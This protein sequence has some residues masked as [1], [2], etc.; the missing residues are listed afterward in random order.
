MRTQSCAAVK[1]RLNDREIAA[2]KRRRV[3]S[4]ERTARKARRQRKPTLATKESPLPVE[5]TLQLD[6]REV[7]GRGN[8]RGRRAD[9][10][11]PEWD[12]GSACVPI[13]AR[14][15]P[16]GWT[17]R[18]AARSNSLA[19][20]TLSG[21]D[22]DRGG[23]RR[24]EPCGTTVVTATTT[25]SSVS[26][27][28][29]GGNGR[30]PNLAGR[31]A[32]RRG[33]IAQLF[34]RAAECFFDERSVAGR[35]AVCSIARGAASANTAASCGWRASLLSAAAPSCSTASEKPSRTLRRTPSRIQPNTPVLL[36]ASPCKEVCRPAGPAAGKMPGGE[37][38]TKGARWYREAPVRKRAVRP[39]TKRR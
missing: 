4:A 27:R 37:P 2:V 18:E 10:C 8:T 23:R 9:R 22:S 14:G 31:V 3:A 36:I 35:S 28:L 34:E 25:M 33:R 29:S 15:V 20:N 11:F 1:C 21:A 13:N 30:E 32:L 26:C 16:G 6:V 38:R 19:G 39:R 17:T 5:H 24:Y 7:W 12:C